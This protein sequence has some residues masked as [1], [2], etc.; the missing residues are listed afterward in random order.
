M[1]HHLF[2]VT[3]AAFSFQVNSHCWVREH[4]CNSFTLL[5]HPTPEI[6]LLQGSACTHTSFYLITKILTTRCIPAPTS[7][8]TTCDVD[9]G[10]EINPLLPKLCLVL[11]LQQKPEVRWSARSPFASRTFSSLLSVVRRS[12]Y[13]AQ[14]GHFELRIP[15]PL[16]RKAGITEIFLCAFTNSPGSIHVAKSI[17]VLMCAPACYLVT[18]GCILC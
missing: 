3:T 7:S 4:V 2:P 1:S 15:L 14:D 11:S 12:Q 8:A 5:C 16:A 10:D 18:T 17:W 13:Q 9:V 6:Y